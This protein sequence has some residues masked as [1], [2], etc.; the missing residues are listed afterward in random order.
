MQKRPS[1]RTSLIA[2]IVAVLS[3]FVLLAIVTTVYPFNSTQLNEQER[4]EWEQLIQRFHEPRAMGLLI[5]PLVG[6]IHGGGLK[7]SEEMMNLVTVFY[8]NSGRQPAINTR[9]FKNRIASFLNSDNDDNVTCAAI[10]LGITGDLS[11]APQLATLLDKRDP[12]DVHGNFSRTSVAFALSLMGAKDYVPKVALMLK[13]KHAQY[14]ASAA[15]ALGQFKAKEY[16]KDVAKLLD[17][18]LVKADAAKVLAIMGASEYADQVARLLN[19]NDE[20]NRIAAL[21]AL[22]IM[23][24]NKYQ[25]RV[26]RHLKEA[27]DIVRFCAAIALVLMDADRYA[28][29]ITPKMKRFYRENSRWLEQEFDPLVPD[30]LQQIDSRFRN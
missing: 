18:E 19:D 29:T 17:D 23:R 16:A 11:F 20:T 25:Q 27:D 15:I 12:P 7:I 3:V 8:G 14:R 10:M 2:R 22:G 26:A 9:E 1:H 5:E 24:A 6:G 28:K 21:L 4:H 30:E 13:S